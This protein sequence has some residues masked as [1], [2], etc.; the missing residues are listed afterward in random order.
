MVARASSLPRW[1]ASVWRATQIVERVVAGLPL[2]LS[3]WPAPSSAS[4]YF[5]SRASSCAKRLRALSYAPVSSYK[6]G[7]REQDFV[8]ARHHLVE[9]LVVPDGFADCRAESA[10]GLP[11][12]GISPAAEARQRRITA[13]PRYVSASLRWPSAAYA[14][15]SFE[16][17]RANSRL[18][19]RRPEILHGFQVRAAD[20]SARGLRC[21]SAA[22]GPISTT[23]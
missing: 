21:S 3:T 4:M 1:T 8:A 19:R 9:V 14:S 23:A 22:P 5:G 10:S 2:Q 7:E 20:G 15:A 11:G 16:Y 6:A 17:A 13:L 12:S 18:R